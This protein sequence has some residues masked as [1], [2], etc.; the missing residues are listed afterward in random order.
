MAPLCLLSF[1]YGRAASARVGFYR[2]GRW[3]IHSL[4]CQVVSVGNITLGGTGKTP[5]VILLAGMLG[6]RGRRVAVLSRGYGGRFAGSCGLVSDGSRLWMDAF[7]AGDEPRL[8]AERLPGVPVIVGRERWLSGKLAVERFGAE[9]VLLDDGFQHLS[10]KRDLDLVLLD[11]AF[12]L[13]NGW[14][15]PRGVLRERT[16]ELCRADAFILTKAGRSDNNLRKNQPW[17]SGKPIFRTDYQADKIRVRGEEA[18]LR[19][20]ALRGRRILAFAGLAQPDSFFR[21]LSELGA[22]VVEA[23]I[24]P[25]HHRYTPRDMAALQRR[26]GRQKAEALVTTEK[27]LVRLGERRSESPSVWALAVRHVFPE[28]DRRRFEDFLFSRLGRG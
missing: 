2:R 13:G 16:G 21:L 25:D 17:P 20:Q 3:K 15:F 26:A 6:E 10:L 18:G 7:Q 27:D 14:V 28:D 5:M 4:P 1:L 24:F 12:L 9:V 23:V 22:Q 8:L 11:S 19:P